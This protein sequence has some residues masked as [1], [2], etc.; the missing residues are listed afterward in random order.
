MCVCIYSCKVNDGYLGQ[1]GK[2]A[3]LRSSCHNG[4]A[5]EYVFEALITHCVV[6]N[7]FKQAN[8][9]PSTLCLCVHVSVFRHLSR[10]GTRMSS[11]AG[12]PPAFETRSGRDPV[13]S[14][15]AEVP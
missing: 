15:P 1:M 14:D 4:H 11:R 3:S 12:R 2:L 13:N 7:P 5:F 10:A 9:P 8:F 6:A